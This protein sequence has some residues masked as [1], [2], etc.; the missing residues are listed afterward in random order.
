[1]VSDTP[2]VATVPATVQIPAGA[3]TVNV[4]VTAVAAGTAKITASGASLNNT[5]ADITVNAVLTIT[6][7]SLPAGVVG[8]PYSQTLGATG[9]KTPYTWSITSG[10]LPAGLT[11]NASTGQ[12]TGVQYAA[13]LPGC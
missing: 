3:N 13:D 5:V 12:I 1:L 11:L 6:T 8:T 9:G 7:T 2:A 10:T 4:P